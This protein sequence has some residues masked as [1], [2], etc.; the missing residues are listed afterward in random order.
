MAFY[1][2]CRR[3]DGTGLVVQGVCPACD[4]YGGYWVVTSTRG[5]GLYTRL[6]PGDADDRPEEPP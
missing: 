1:L 5:G 3:C 4:G 6:V 2:R